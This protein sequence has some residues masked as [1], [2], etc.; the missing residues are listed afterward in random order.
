M[1]QMNRFFWKKASEVSNTQATRAKILRAVSYSKVLDV[2]PYCSDQLK[3]QLQTGRDYEKKQLLEQKEH[4][5][6]QFEQYKQGKDA[7]DTK[8]LFRDFKKMTDDQR[9]KD[10][11]QQLYRPHGFGLVYMLNRKPATTS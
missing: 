3:Q 5:Q 9:V 6:D 8:Q 10:H 4:E 7:D 1:V 11:D 2:F